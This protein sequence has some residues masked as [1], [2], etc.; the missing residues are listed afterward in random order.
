VMPLVLRMVEQLLNPN[1]DKRAGDQ[2]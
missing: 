1:N 2:L